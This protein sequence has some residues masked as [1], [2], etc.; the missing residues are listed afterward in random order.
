MASQTELTGIKST[1][2]R[3]LIRGSPRQP[4]VNKARIKVRVEH[5]ENEP[6][7]DHRRDG[8]LAE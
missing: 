1:G 2:L 8:N 3:V 6:A 7:K 5:R 4:G